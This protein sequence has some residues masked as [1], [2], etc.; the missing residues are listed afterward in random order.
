MANKVT[1]IEQIGEL[2]K[3][4]RIEGISEIRDQDSNKLKKTLK[5]IFY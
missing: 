4:K 5:Q 3:E 2:V 1:L